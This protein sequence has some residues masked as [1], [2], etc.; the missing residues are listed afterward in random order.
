MYLVWHDSYSVGYG[1]IDAQHQ[2]LFAISNRLTDA[3]EKAEGANDDD[4][5]PIIAELLA[6]TRTHFADE[7]QL[8]AKAGYPDLAQHHAVHVVFENQMRELEAQVKKGEVRA[9]AL[10]LPQLLN[11][12]LLDHI[13]TTDQRYRSHV[14]P[15]MASA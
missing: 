5:R 15:E 11:D 10:A 3:V 13:A 7:E 1:P 12:W 4:L 6:Y 14:H 8:M 2:N 9:V